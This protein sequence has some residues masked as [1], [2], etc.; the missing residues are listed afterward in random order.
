MKKIGLLMTVMIVVLTF[1]KSQQAQGTIADIKPAEGMTIRSDGG[2]Y[3]QA[4]GTVRA[5][6]YNNMTSVAKKSN[7]CNR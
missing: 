1:A 7:G 5:G 6:L 2:T 3:R 4:S